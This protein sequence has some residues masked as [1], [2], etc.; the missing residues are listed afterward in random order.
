MVLRIWLSPN[1]ALM[2][3]M[4]HTGQAL[5][6]CLS[7]GNKD[8]PHK[9]LPIWYKDAMRSSVNHIQVSPALG[10]AMEDFTDT[11]RVE[12]IRF[13]PVLVL[14]QPLDIANHFE[15]TIQKFLRGRSRT[16][17]HLSY[18]VTHMIYDDDMRSCIWAS[19]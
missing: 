1:Y 3:G 9:I 8:P 10:T 17:N 7:L 6:R 16:H 5:P 11:N 19:I 15:A 2:H 4:F 12:K 13:V 18:P 14:L